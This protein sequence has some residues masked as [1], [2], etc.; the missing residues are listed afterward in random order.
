MIR[1]CFLVIFALSLL[2]ACDSLVKD[3]TSETDQTNQPTDLV[4]SQVTLTGPS[5]II[6]DESCVAMTVAALNSSGQQIPFSNELEILFADTTDGSTAISF[7]TD[8]NCSAFLSDDKVLIPSGSTNFN[9]YFMVSDLVTATIPFGSRTISATATSLQI[10]PYVFSVQ[11]N[12]AAKFT[13]FNISPSHNPFQ[14]NNCYETYLNVL[15]ANDR[16]TVLNPN[17]NETLQ[18]SAA[19]VNGANLYLDANCTTQVNTVVL[20]AGSSWLGPVYFSITNADT[21]NFI[22]LTFASSSGVSGTAELP[23]NP[24]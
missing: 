18:F 2:V 16:D 23:V 3:K 10:A 1:V 9:V 24:N 7:S 12:P 17:S 11:P 21:N 15:A 20:Q 8:S 6:N 4:V 19:P 22:N 5:E 13:L 14:K